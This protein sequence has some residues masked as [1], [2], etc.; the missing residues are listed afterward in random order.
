[1]IINIIS[2]SPF[3]FNL[4]LKYPADITIG[5]DYGAFRVIDNNM[6]LDCCFGDFDSVSTYQFVKLLNTC[7]KINKYKKEKDKTDT[8]IALDYAISLNPDTIQLFGVTG[9]RIDH[10]LSALGLFNKVLE[11]DGQL[12]IIDEYN[13][14]YIKKP[15]TYTIVKTDYKYLSLFS[16]Q[17]EVKNLS[18][19]N[20]KY[21]LENYLLS[22]Q[23]SLCISNEIIGDKGIISFDEGILL[24]VESID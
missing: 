17:N 10:F 24:I 6:S 11:K 22:N 1:M 15:G 18:L 9:K 14:I 19:V 12:V 4:V 23:D 7:S 21:K 20:F 3:D 5:V 16:Y 13:K 8:E 2:G